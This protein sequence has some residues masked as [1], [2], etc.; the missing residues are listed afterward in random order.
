M[1]ETGHLEILKKKCH[2]TAARDVICINKDFKWRDFFKEELFQSQATG[3]VDLET[4][5]GC[6]KSKLGVKFNFALNQDIWLSLRIGI[7][8]SNVQKHA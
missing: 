4:F 2:K 1:L 3:S 6:L 7:Q 8:G 5:I